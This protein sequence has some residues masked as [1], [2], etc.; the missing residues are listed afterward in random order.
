MNFVT[1]HVFNVDYILWWQL[2]FQIGLYCEKF[3]DII[4]ILQRAG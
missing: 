4:S 1:T 3:S 2:I